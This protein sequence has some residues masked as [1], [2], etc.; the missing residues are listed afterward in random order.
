MKEVKHFNDIT[1]YHFAAKVRRIG[2]NAIRQAQ[3]EN[4]RLGLPNVFSQNGIIY[5]EMPEGNI[6]TQSPFEDLPEEGKTK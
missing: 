5:Y 4:R 1:L 6:T 3:E 2:N